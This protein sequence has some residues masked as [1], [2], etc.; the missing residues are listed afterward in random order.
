MN[1]QRLDTVNAAVK[2][3]MPDVSIEL[4]GRA[5]FVNF[6]GYRS[7]GE[8]RPKKRKQ[9]I[10]VSEGSHFPRWSSEFPHG[11]TCHAALHQLVRFAQEK[12]VVTIGAWEAWCGP[13]IRV[14]GDNGQAVVDLLRAGGWPTVATCV[15][16]GR[17]PL[18]RYDWWSLEG[19]SGPACYN[20]EECNPEL[21]L[22]RSHRKEQRS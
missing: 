16:C 10:A 8:T 22:P 19:V 18:P 6:L 13:N 9:W 7:Y 15:V 5:A 17:T 11:G 20:H 12:P 1:Q 2:L 14:A 4:E 21:R 3:I